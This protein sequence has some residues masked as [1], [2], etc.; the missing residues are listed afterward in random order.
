MFGCNCDGGC[1]TGPCAKAS[2]LE[3]ASQTPMLLAATSSELFDIAD[4][5][6]N[7][8][9]TFDEWRATSK[10]ET[11]GSLIELWAM[12]DT[13]N[14]GYLTKDEAINRKASIS[15]PDSPIK[16]ESRVEKATNPCCK[17]NDCGICGDG[18]KG[19]PYCG[20]GKCNFAGCDCDGGC[21]QGT[22]G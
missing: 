8:K 17:A 12:Y 13:S 11:D 5:D 21:R 4:T 6:G 14:K 2:S 9:I 16:S 10:L 22:C 20:Y 3:S 7:G 19:T 18:T 15:A 1:R